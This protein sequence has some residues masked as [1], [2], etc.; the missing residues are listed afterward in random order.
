MLKNQKLVKFKTKEKIVKSKK[1]VYF[2]INKYNKL[3]KKQQ[4]LIQE[5]KRNTPSMIAF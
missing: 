4:L 3:I 5:Y 2:N 1:V